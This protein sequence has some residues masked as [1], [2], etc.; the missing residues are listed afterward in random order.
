MTHE[1][2]GS[3]TVMLSREQAVKLMAISVMLKDEEL[4]F[5]GEDAAK[6]LDEMSDIGEE[7]ALQL[8]GYPA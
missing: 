8:V 4:A 3:E 1:S 2:L 7:L 5:F 6:A